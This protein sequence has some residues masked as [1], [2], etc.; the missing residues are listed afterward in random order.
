MICIYLL[1]QY[2]AVDCQIERSLYKTGLE[3]GPKINL[4]YRRYTLFKSAK[5]FPR[6]SDTER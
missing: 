6:V 1:F 5:E 4:K 3:S 2:R